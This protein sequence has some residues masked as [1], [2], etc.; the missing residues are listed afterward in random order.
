VGLEYTNATV[1]C[2]F[3]NDARLSS[4]DLVFVGEA[5]GFPG[6]FGPRLRVSF[7]CGCR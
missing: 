7:G 4:G 3:R 5:A 1:T 2:Y 6:E